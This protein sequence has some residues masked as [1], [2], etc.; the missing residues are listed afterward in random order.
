MR[1]TKFQDIF[2]LGLDPVASCVDR[3]VV[4]EIPQSSVGFMAANK[5][6]CELM[7]HNLNHDQT[8]IEEIVSM[9]NSDWR[10]PFAS[11]NTW[12]H[13]CN[14]RCT[15]RAHCIQKAR[16]LL[17][18]V[19]QRFPQVP[20]LYRWKGWEECLDYVLRLIGCSFSCPHLFPAPFVLWKIQIAKP[21][22]R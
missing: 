22:I 17:R 20:L 13:Y 1:S 19:Y 4:V 15:D 14:G 2:N 16:E 10:V 6:L 18:R 8:L 21:A 7:G 9:F 5:I 12:L 3:R 11:D